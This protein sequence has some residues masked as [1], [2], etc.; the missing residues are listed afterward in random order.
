MHDDEVLSP[1][2]AAAAFGVSPDSLRKWANEGLFEFFS[3][4]G[5]HYRYRRSVLEAF[6]T[7]SKTEPEP[8]T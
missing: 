8:A 3:T 5:D 4:P 2:E 1:S 7:S 6:F